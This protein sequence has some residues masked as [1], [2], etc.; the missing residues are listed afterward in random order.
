MPPL[1]GTR[2]L[3]PIPQ[4]G[5]AALV[6]VLVAGIYVGAGLPAIAPL[7][8]AAVLLAASALL[9]GAAGLQLA[10]IRAFAW[11]RFRQVGGWL[12]LAEAIVSGMLE[13]VFVLDGIRGALLAVFTITLVIFALDVP[14]IAAFTVARFQDPSPRPSDRSAG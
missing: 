10:G 6:L 11:W 9:L 2:R 7:A 14:L 4:L 1:S 3:P 12:L 8:P 5:I 13:V